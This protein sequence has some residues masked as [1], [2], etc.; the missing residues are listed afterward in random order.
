MHLGMA[1]FMGLGIFGA[2]M[3]VFTVAAFGVGAE[4]RREGQRAPAQRG[5]G[6]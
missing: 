6:A 1:L 5:S 4:P 3:I 2:M